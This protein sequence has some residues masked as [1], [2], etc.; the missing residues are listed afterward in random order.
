MVKQVQPAS[1][2]SPF[3]N[4][5]QRSTLRAMPLDS[6]PSPGDGD[7]LPPDDW[8]V[9]SSDCARGPDGRRDQV[10][11]GLLLGYL[12]FTVQLECLCVG[13]ACRDIGLFRLNADYCEQLAQDAFRVQCDEAFHALLCEQLASHVV[14][15][16]GVPSR[17]RGEHAFLREVRRLRAIAG[18]CVSPAQFDFCVAAV[19]ETVITKSLLRDWRNSAIKPAVREFLQGHF[20]DEIRHSTFFA[21]TLRVVW[22]QWDPAV[23]EAIAP[24]W[25]ALILAFVTP[26]VE[27][28]R[29]A[30]LRSGVPPEQA[31]AT[32]ADYQQRAETATAQRASYEMTLRMLSSLDVLDR[33]QGVSNVQRDAILGAM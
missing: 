16:S 27:I 1:Y 23:R 2:Q 17:Y 7:W 15:E 4:W 18:P 10:A 26:D 30:L 21:Q 12:D 25:P 9:A 24:L 19:A 20:R 11:A 22:P 6:W 28:A 13:P 3:A 33:Q 14:R 5:H 32:A 31:C 29:Q 8:N